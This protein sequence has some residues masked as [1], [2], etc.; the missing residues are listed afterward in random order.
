[1]HTLN[2]SLRDSE[3]GP[4]SNCWMSEDAFGFNAAEK[5]GDPLCKNILVIDDINDS[6]AT[7]EWIKQD[8][9]SSCLPGDPRWQHVWGQNVRFA[10]LTHNHASKFIDPDYHA[11]EVNKAEEDCWLV[12]PWEEFWK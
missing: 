8:W 7:I 6:G 5:E 10:V 11:W 4:E 1:M 3:Q 9:E 2:V 12:Y